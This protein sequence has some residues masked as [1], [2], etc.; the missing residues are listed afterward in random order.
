[1]SKTQNAVVDTGFSCGR[2]YLTVNG[3]VVAMEGD[4]CRDAELPSS[5]FDEKLFETI[6]KGE[7]EDP[8]K[9]FF[10]PERYSSL[11]A[12]DARA[13]YLA[14]K[15]KEREELNQFVDEHLK[16]TFAAVEVTSEESLHLW[17]EW[18]EEHTDRVKDARDQRPLVY[19]E[20]I[21]SGFNQT[22]GVF[23]FEKDEVMPVCISGYWVR[24]RGKKTDPGKLVLLYEMTSQVVDYR[25]VDRWMEENLPKGVQTSDAQNFHNI[26]H[27]VIK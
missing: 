16:N 3:F 8:K 10:G 2:H 11:P 17:R 20:Q 24:L 19:W 14:R 21:P 4:V 9:L 7:H 26:V 13:Q 27:R 1:M 25:M 23:K 6:I 12:I 5:H 18:A 22:I 15:K